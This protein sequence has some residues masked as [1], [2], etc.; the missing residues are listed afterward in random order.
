MGSARKFIVNGLFRRAYKYGYVAPILSFTSRYP[1][2]TNVFEKNWETLILLDTCRVDALRTMVPEYEF[3]SNPVGKLLSVG[4]TSSEW[5]AHT[6]TETHRDTVSKTAY[7]SANGHAQY[8]LEDGR[9][10]EEIEGVPARTRWRTVSSETLGSLAHVWQYD[11]GSPGHIRPEAVTDKAIE[12]G[13][14]GDCDRLIIHYSQPHAPY[15]ARAI[16]SGDTMCDYEKQPFQY[17]L[18]DGSRKQVFESY[19]ENL[20]FV[21]DS[22][23]VLLNN[24]DGGRTIISAD[25]GEAFGEWSFYGHQIAA[26]HPQIKYVP[27]AKTTATDQRTHVPDRVWNDESHS[28]EEHL[29]ALGY[30]T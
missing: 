17:L 1:I 22:V 24:L 3:L 14:S 9:R 15:A 6:F 20:R 12:V 18:K 16:K 7:I 25:H 4:S 30:K 29:K 10:P 13:R 5:I 19:L 27:W 8:V 21:L 11:A 23:N 2:G 26:L 28:V